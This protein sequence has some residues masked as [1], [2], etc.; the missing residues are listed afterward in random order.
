MR[1]RVPFEQIAAQ[2]NKNTRVVS[3]SSVE[4][5]SGFR[6]D[7]NRIGRFCKER[8]ILFCVDA[9]QSLGVLPM[10]VKADHID[11]LA[12]DGHKWLLSVEGLGGFYISKRVLDR[13]HPAVVG[14]DSV[15]NAQDYLHYDFTLRPDARRFEEGSFNTMSIHAFGAALDLLL[16]VGIDNIEKRVLELGDLI[17]AKVQE[18]GWKQVSS[19]EPAERSGIVSFAVDADVEGLKKEMAAHHITITIRDGIVRLSPHF[20]NTEIEIDKCLAYIDEF[21]KK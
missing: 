19:T 5:N 11:C 7:L 14:W 18:H 13:I 1:G 16:E 4:A 15:V 2:V 9:I 17:I 10:D 12:A 3:V 8:G 21:A 6:N 20:Y